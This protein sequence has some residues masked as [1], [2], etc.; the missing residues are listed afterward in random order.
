[1]ASLDN[2]DEVLSA[3]RS[4]SESVSLNDLVSWINSHVL[5][6]TLSHCPNQLVTITP[7]LLLG[8]L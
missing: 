7:S 1:M 2:K 3:L 4:V 6:F 8:A 5:P